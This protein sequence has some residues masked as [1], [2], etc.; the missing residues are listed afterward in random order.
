MKSTFTNYWVKLGVEAFRNSIDNPT[1]SEEERNWITYLSNQMKNYLTATTAVVIFFFL[2]VNPMNQLKAQANSV[3]PQTAAHLQTQLDILL[4][5]NNLKGLS[6]TVIIP[7]KGTWKGVSGISHASVPID[8]AM[9]FR[10]ASI[11]KNFTATAIL[12]LQEDGLLSISDSL[13]EFL[14]TYPH[15]DSNITIK[16]LLQHTSGIYNYTN[17]SNFWS[18]VNSIPTQAMTPQYVLNNFI[19]APPFAP[20][21]IHYYSNTNYLLLRIIIEE[22]TGQSYA[23]FIRQRLLDPLQLTSFY[24]AVQEPGMGVMPHNWVGANPW[25]AGTDIYNYPMTAMVGTSV[26]DNALVGNA[27]DLARWGQHLFTGQ[28]LEPASLQLMKQFHYFN[29]GMITGY[30]LGLIRY[31]QGNA[32][33]WG[34]GGQISGFSSSFMFSASDNIVVSV[35]SNRQTIGDN[36]A[37]PLLAAARHQLPTGLTDEADGQRDALVCFPNPVQSIGNIKYTLQQ[38]QHIE[39]TL[40]N[41]LGQTVRTLVSQ[42]QQSGEHSLMVNTSTLPSGM[43]FCTMQ[44]NGSKLVQRWIVAN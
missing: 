3:D 24:V 11:T 14:P 5:A 21:A 32:E 17:N 19:N 10:L 38:A 20:G 33:A 26:G 43:Y 34:H 37:W 6:A 7:G 22:V 2:L 30:G 16:Q 18:A 29:G 40:Q 39:I 28:V 35:L 9:V 41:N 4:S 12:L 23:S 15:I 44:T 25:D 13:H 1:E 31:A 42:L 27:Y 8:T 36:L